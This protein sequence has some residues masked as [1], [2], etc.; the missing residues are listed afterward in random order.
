M[1]TELP[2]WPLRWEGD[3]LAILDQTALPEEQRVLRLASAEEVAEAI[4]AMRIRG[5][6]ALGVAGAYGVALAAR[7]AAERGGDVRAA[8]AAGARVLRAARPTAANLAAQV[9][10]MARAAVAGAGVV[11]LVGL[12]RAIHEEDLEL[13]RRLIANGLALLAPA[14]RYLTHCHTGPL[15]TGGEGTALGVLLAGHARGR[16]ARVWVDETRPRLQGARL[17]AL[18]LARAGVPFTVIADSAA[19]ALLAAGAVDQVWVGA[20]RVARNGDVVNKVGTYSLALACAAH[21]VPL[22]VAFPW[23]TFDPELAEGGSCPIEERDQAEVLELAGRRV[24]AP[25]AGAFNPAFDVT[26]A[27]RVAAWVTDRGVARSAGDLAR[28]AGGD[29]GA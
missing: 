25:A 23:S 12:A 28:L 11:E 1:S 3:A 17:T 26:P 15:A 13:S 8:A 7:R 9:D 21:G 29:V 27:A 20:D 24:A 19:A 6:P 4:A 16:V 18:E 5:A 14:G 22:F 10:R 2:P